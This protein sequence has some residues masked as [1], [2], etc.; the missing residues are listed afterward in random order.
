MLR[1]PFFPTGATVSIAATTTTGNVA[2]T[3]ATSKNPELAGTLRVVNAGTTVMFFKQGV[4]GSLAATAADVPIAPGATETFQLQADT[5][6]VAALT[7]SSTG[8]I[9]FTPGQGG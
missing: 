3:P 7:A 9:Y 6:H 2:I 5:D 4:G 1:R 8:T